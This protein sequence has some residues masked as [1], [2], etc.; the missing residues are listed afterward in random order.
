MVYL[1]DILIYL[2]TLVEHTTH[3]RTTLSLLS[4]N[5]LYGKLSKC[6]LFHEH[7]EFLG[8][9]VDKDGVHIKGVE[10]N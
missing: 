5:R 6:S 1:D 2:R 10:G 8:H 7:V 9:V 4:D 3:V